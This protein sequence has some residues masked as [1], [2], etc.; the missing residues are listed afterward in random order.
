VEQ[1][2]WMSQKEFVDIV[3]ISQVTPGPIGMNCATYVGY[4][5]TDSI[6]GSITASVAV[7]LP[8][9]IIMF[10]L[11]RLYFLMQKRYQN[12]V[13]YVNTLRGI[14][15]LVLGL[16]GAAALSLMTQDSFFD[17]SSWVIFGTVFVL[18]ILPQLVSKNCVRTHKVVTW[19]ANPILL[20]L[21][22]GVAGY[23]LY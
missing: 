11:C 10:I 14:R 17:W 21:M 16:I 15:F 8:S 6:L 13:Y 4:T 9:L 20:I 5:A 7:V 22:A 3:A 2:G 12:N 1:Y 19:L 23:L 18:G